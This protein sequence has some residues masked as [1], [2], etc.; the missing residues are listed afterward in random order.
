MA[1]DYCL[2]IIYNNYLVTIG[3]LLNN[4]GNIMLITNNNNHK[5]QYNIKYIIM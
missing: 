3:N 4:P 1:D 2:I 5:Q